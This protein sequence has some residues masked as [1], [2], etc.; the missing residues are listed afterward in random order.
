MIEGGA[1]TATRALLEGVV[2]KVLFFYGPKII[3][4]DGTDMIEPLGIKKLSRARKLKDV[5]FLR[6]GDDLLISGYL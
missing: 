4:G 2:D 1:A 3:G 6:L 5:E